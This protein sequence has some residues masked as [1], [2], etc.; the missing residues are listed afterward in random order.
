VDAARA[1]GGSW[2]PRCSASRHMHSAGVCIHGPAVPLTIIVVVMPVDVS[3]GS[4]GLTL[5]NWMSNKT[6]KTNCLK[7]VLGDFFLQLSLPLPRWRSSWVR[8]ER[9]RT[10]RSPSGGPRCPGSPLTASVTTL[11]VRVHVISRMA[12]PQHSL[13]Q[14]DRS[15]AEASCAMLDIQHRKSAGSGSTTLLYAPRTVSLAASPL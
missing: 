13:F 12:A 5:Q 15:L 1:T 10:Q 7:R 4:S 9:R 14:R 2:S 11:T 8:R 3:R 6:I